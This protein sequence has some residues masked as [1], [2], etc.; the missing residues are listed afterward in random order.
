MSEERLKAFLEIVKLDDSLQVRIKQSSNVHQ[1]V[2]LAK[3]L[4]YY[5]SIDDL[6][7]L[8]D[9]EL[10]DDDLNEV[11]GGRRGNTETNVMT[12]LMNLKNKFN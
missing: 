4:G 1:F 9:E 12:L 2:A 11:R 8:I 5:F 10:S 3:E 7:A 6:K